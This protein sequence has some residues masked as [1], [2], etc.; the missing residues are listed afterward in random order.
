[1]KAPDLDKLRQSGRISATAREHGKKMIVPGARAKPLDPSLLQGAG[2]VP[3]GTKV[4]IDATIPE[5]IPKEHYEKVRR[6]HPTLP[7][8]VYPAGHGFSCDARGSYHEPS[9]RL[10]RERSLAFFRQ[11]VG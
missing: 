8:H 2:V 4:G 9:A 3:I 5:H 7:V 6:I 1:M 10:A 11:H